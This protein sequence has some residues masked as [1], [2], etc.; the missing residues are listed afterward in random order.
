MPTKKKRGEREK[1]LAELAGRLGVTEEEAELRAL[2]DLAARTAPPDR[3]AKATPEPAHAG[4]LPRRLFVLLDGRGLDGRGL[5]IEVLKSPTLIGTGKMCEIWVNS[6]QVE[7]RHL[8]ITQ[9]G[10]DWIAQDLGTEKGTLLDDKPLRKRVIQHGDEYR[11]AGY[12]RVRAE[13]H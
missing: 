9:E 8:Q 4:G 13:F 2:R 5:P 7:T 3:P 11:L 1:L 12:L 6:P 10:D